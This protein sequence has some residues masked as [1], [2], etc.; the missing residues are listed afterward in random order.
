[1]CK[2]TSRLYAKLREDVS[3]QMKNDNPNT[4]GVARL[5]Y[6]AREGKQPA[7]PNWKIGDEARKRLSEKMLGDKNPNAGGIARKKAVCLLNEQR[8]IVHRFDS[9]KIAE[10]YTSANHA[11]VFNNRTR[12]TMYRGYYWVFEA[13][14]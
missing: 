4:G 1:M 5:A 8:E 2:T 3:T 7:R 13:E 14:L 12:G 9:L 6:I 10:E 11:S